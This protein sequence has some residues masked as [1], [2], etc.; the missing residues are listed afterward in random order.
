M[1]SR[2]DSVMQTGRLLVLAGASV[3]VNRLVDTVAA[4]GAALAIGDRAARRPSEVVRTV[5]LWRLRMVLG[6]MLT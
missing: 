3:A 4:A 1:G 2:M 5:A 6:A